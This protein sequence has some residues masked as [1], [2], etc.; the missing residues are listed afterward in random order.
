MIEDFD[1]IKRVVRTH[2][3]DVLDHQDLNALLDNPTAE[4][5]A[6]WIWTQLDERLP[7]LDEV[8]LWETATSCAVLNRS[9]MH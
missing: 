1:T 6:M 5:I 9:D 7:A 4:H 3:L 2:V 8:V